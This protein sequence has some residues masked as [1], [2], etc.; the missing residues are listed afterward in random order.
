MSIE[1]VKP[2]EK[3]TCKTIGNWNGTKLYNIFIL[4]AFNYFTSVIFEK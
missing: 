2:V 1:K 4:L 3:K